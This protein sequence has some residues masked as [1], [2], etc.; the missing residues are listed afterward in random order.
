MPKAP[1]KMGTGKE[2]IHILIVTAR[3]DGLAVFADSLDK[4]KPV[5]VHRRTSG[6]EALDFVAQKDIALVVAEADLGDMGGI[7]FARKL[8]AQ[9]PMTGCALVSSLAPD[10]FHEATEG[11]GILMQLPPDPGDRQARELFEKLEMVTG[12][13][14]AEAER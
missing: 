10:A 13:V 1:T 12:L 2:M 6:E 3:D 11:L 7:D 14:A 8:V 9:S 4:I 5:E